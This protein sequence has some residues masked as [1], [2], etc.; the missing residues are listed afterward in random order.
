LPPYLWSHKIRSGAKL[1][2]L[3]LR[4]N[5]AW[6]WAFIH[7]RYHDS[8][9]L[10][11]LTVKDE[12]TG[13]CLTIETDR[14]LQ[15]THLKALLRELIIR[16]GRPRVIRSDNGS[17]LPAQALREDFRRH[18]IELANIDAGKPTQNGSSESI[19]ARYR[20]EWLNAEIFAS[21]I[22]AREVIEQW[23]RR[24]NERRQHNSQNYIMPNMAY[25]ALTEVRKA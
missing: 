13:Y 16:Y 24:Y 15:H 11:R 12:A 9:P 5:D 10:R 25:F 3:A 22:E 20:K 4:R 23:R 6:A 19:N 17:E 14:H 7:D 1:D 8:Q 2:G 18:K 21:L